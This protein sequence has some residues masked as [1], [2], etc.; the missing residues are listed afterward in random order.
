MEELIYK[1]TLQHKTKI[2]INIKQM[3]LNV[4]LLLWPRFFVFLLLIRLLPI[5]RQIKNKVGV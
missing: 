2:N 3:E 4:I 1:Q 5:F